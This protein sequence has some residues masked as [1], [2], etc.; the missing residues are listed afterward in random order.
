MNGN[1]IPQVQSSSVGL[2]AN[3]TTDVRRRQQQQ[4]QQQP[5]I[6]EIRDLRQ[7]HAAIRAEIRRL[8]DHQ[9]FSIMTGGRQTWPKDKHLQVNNSNVSN[10]LKITKKKKKKKGYC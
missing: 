6:A 5:W 1:I 8:T 4:Q 9:T 3:S 2:R 7:Q 10:T